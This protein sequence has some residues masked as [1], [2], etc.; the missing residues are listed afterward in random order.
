MK[1]VVSLRSVSFGYDE[2]LVLDSVSLDIFEGDY[3]GIVGPNGSGKSTL[4]KLML[5]IIKPVKGEI[6]LFGTNIDSFKDWGK[7]G[8]VPQKA[9]SFNTGFPATVEEVV[10]A[11]LYS[12]IGL[13][14]PMKKEHRDNIYKALEIVGL[15][16]CSKRLIGSLSGGQQQKVFI[17]RT[18]VSSPQVI[19]LDEPTVGIDAKSQDGFFKLLSTLNNDM[20]ITIAMISHDIGVIT[21]KA[22]RV[23]CVGDKRVIIHSNSSDIHSGKI[24]NRLYGENMR[25]LTH[26]H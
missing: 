2:G 23:A 1:K 12:K 5:G 11:N 26:A 6:E 24:L 19:F 4:L 10:G 25:I 18:L 9:A 21:E 14:K 7:I 15:K 16:E 17:A 20:N 13:F 3:I 22:D 8:Y